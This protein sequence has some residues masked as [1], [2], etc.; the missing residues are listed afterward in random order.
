MFQDKY[1][2]LSTG[3]TCLFKHRDD[4]NCIDFRSCFR[5]QN[6]YEIKNFNNIQKLRVTL[7]SPR[8]VLILFMF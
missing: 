2:K 8:Q 7:C 4:Y 5:V 3:Y 1:M 6:N